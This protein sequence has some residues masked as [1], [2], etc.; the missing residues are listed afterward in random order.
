MK[1]IETG[2]L[3]LLRKGQEQKVA[4]CRRRRR[5]CRRRKTKWLRPFFPRIFRICRLLRI[6]WRGRVVQVVGQLVESEG[7]FCTVGEA[8]EIID[9]RGEHWAGEMSDFAGTPC[10]R[11]RCAVRREYGTAM[12]SCWE[13]ALVAPQ[14][15]ITRRVLDGA[16]NPIDGRAAPVCRERCVLDREAPLALERTP[17]RD[18]LDRIRAIAP[19]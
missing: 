4:G 16:G 9:A 5:K 2:L 8:C 12:Q 15:A 17:I 1:E 3:D 10:S 6:A 13:G 7:P 11:W 18:P 19:S 14:R